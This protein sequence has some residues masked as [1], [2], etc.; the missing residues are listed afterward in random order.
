MYQFEAFVFHM[1]V[2]WHKLGEVENECI[3]HNSIVLALVVQKNYQI[4]W[5][6]D[7]TITKT[8]FTLFL[9]HG[10]FLRVWQKF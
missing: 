2:H 10:V 8:I 4:W 7:K 1:V 9:R 5:K 3:L 6:F